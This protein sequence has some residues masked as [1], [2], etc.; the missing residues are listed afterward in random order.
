MLALLKKGISSNADVPIYIGGASLIHPRIALTAAHKVHDNKGSPSNVF[1]RGGEW[2]TK[3]TSELCD[4]IDN[5]VE[6]IIVHEDYRHDIK[7]YQNSIALLILKES[8]SLNA[9]INIAC[10]PKTDLKLGNENCFALGWGKD[11]FGSKGVYNNFLKKVELP[12]VDH[13]S[14]QTRLRNSRLGQDFVLH[15]GFMCAGGDQDRD[16]C[17]GDGGG[18]LNCQ[19]GDT[20]HFYQVGIILAGIGCKNEYPAFYADLRY[21]R[22][23]IEDKINEE[24]LGFMKD[25]NHL[26]QRTNQV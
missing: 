13:E 5:E 10:L 6:K 3:V 14:C 25:F 16:T 12:L 8:F 18:P 24:D 1:V 11:K 23:W 19:I 17:L 9:I 7:N 26:G 22:N 21:Y 15:K 20:G 4:H 2:N